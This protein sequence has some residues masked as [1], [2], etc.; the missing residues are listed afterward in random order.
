MMNPGR[1]A[2]ILSLYAILC[3]CLFSVVA[4]QAITELN[5]KVSKGKT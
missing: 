4:V 3:N 2:G 5:N 1:L